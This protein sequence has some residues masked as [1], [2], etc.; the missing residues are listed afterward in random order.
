MR[1]NRMVLLAVL[2]LGPVGLAQKQGMRPLCDDN[3]PPMYRNK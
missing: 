1:K 2:F 3:A